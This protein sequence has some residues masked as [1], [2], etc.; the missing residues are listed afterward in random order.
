MNPGENGDDRGRSGSKGIEN[1][2]RLQRIEG[3]VPAE[4]FLAV[5]IMT[6]GEELRHCMGLEY[7][8]LRVRDF[9]HLVTSEEA[10]AEVYLQD[11]E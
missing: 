6:N 10:E 11:I 2:L 8:A 1:D 4:V 5:S 9:P 7:M 3:H